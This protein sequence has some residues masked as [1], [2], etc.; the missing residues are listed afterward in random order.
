MSFSK[1]IWI[2]SLTGTSPFDIYVCDYT[3][4]ACTPYVVATITELD[5]PYLLIIPPP[6]DIPDII[7]VKVVDAL[8]CEDCTSYD[9]R[10]LTPTVTPTQ[11]ETPT[12]TITN[13]PSRTPS[14]TPTLTPGLPPS[15]TPT[16]TPTPTETP[17]STPTNTPTPT[18]TL[19]PGLPPSS[20]PTN[21]PTPT[22]TLTS[23]LPPSPTPTNTPTPSPTLDVDCIIDV[24]VGETCINDNGGF[25]YNLSGWT[26]TAGDAIW[27]PLWNGTC[28]FE[29]N[30][31]GSCISQDI[32]TIGITYNINFDV[33][34][35]EDIDCDSS[36]TS[37]I[38]FAGD[39]DS[40]V[41]V[42]NVSGSIHI[43]L[44][45]EC[46]GSTNFTICAFSE[47]EG[48]PYIYID[49]VCVTPNI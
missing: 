28:E 20:T 37:V 36:Q 27:A 7:Y 49:N 6:Y 48:S 23:G 41:L 15:S 25:D 5:L 26:V 46:T 47:C 31:F 18:Q 1:E 24:F 35:F 8:G 34:K 13:T 43:S 40:G 10:P 16:N 32:L 19:T 2:L 33:L 4:T 29:N 17:S 12:P 11:T 14:R 21:T 38:V 45:L 9:F 44:Q 22:P 3:C 30:S 39:N 42:Q